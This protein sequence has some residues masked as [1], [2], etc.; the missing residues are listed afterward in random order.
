MTFT[1]E[2]PTSL[3]AA[4]AVRDLLTD[5]LGREVRVEVAKPWKRRSTDLV[6]VAE[7]VDDLPAIGAVT[8]V[9]LPLSVFLGATLGLLPAAGAQRM[10]DERDVSPAVIEN[11]FEVLNIMTSLFNVD[12]APHLKIRTMH[13]PGDEIPAKVNLV[14][15]NP[16]GRLDLKVDIAKYGGGQLAFVIR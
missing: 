7:F 15:N 12:G 6:T 1:T 5:L 3:P 16:S 2:K 11:L 14:V 4:K 10:I 13:R 8:L 9:D